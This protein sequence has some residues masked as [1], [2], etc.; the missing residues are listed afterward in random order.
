MDAL[1]ET[2]ALRRRAYLTFKANLRHTRYGWLR[3]TPAY[4][5]HLVKELLDQYAGHESVVLDPFCG[6]GTTALVCAERG[7]ACDTTDIN[8]FLVWLAKAK[9]R[10]C[11]VPDVRRASVAAGWVNT[12]LL[13]EG[14]VEAWTPPIHQIEKW[15]S[16]GTIRALGRGMAVLAGLQHDVPQVAL[17]LLKVAFCR[18][19]IERANVSFNHQSMSFRKAGVAGSEDDDRS[20]AALVAQTWSVAM[21]EV[22]QG[23]ASPIASTPGI[24]VCDAR[25]LG[26]AL[27]A[28]RYDCVLTSP[29]YP[30]RMSYVRELRPYMYWLGYLDQPRDAGDL[31]WKAMG[32]TWGSATSNVAKWSPPAPAQTGWSGFNEMIAQIAARSDVLARYVHKYFHD[33]VQHAAGLAI[34]VKK[35]GTI[36]YVVGNSKFYNVVVPVEEIL[37][38]T[39]RATGFVDVR[40]RA[41]RKRNSKKELY[42]YRVSGCKA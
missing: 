17:D 27:P 4:S 40:V 9:T 32:G 20:A 6:T 12:A 10:A 15:W 7:I 24:A 42:E 1:A 38:A 23:A 35:G 3:L 13:Q 22:M 14:G 37:A 18:T 8:P 5:V 30:N 29:P 36:H 26:T 2:T 25:Q 28:A 31:D 16:G 34:V 39:F 41:I 33:F 11:T 19:L 21:Q